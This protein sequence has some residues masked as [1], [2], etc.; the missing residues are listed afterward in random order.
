M[1]YTIIITTVGT[2]MFSNYFD[3]NSKSTHKLI[4]DNIKKMSFTETDWSNLSKD[5]S[6]QSFEKEVGETWS[7]FSCAELDT[8]TE[9]KKTYGENV[10]HHLLCSET[11]AGVLA[12]KILDK[13]LGEVK[14]NII[15][16]KLQTHIAKGFKETVFLK[17]VETVQGIAENVNLEKQAIAILLSLEKDEIKQFIKKVLKEKTNIEP[18]KTLFTK[19]TNNQPWKEHIISEQVANEIIVISNKKVVINYSGGYKAVI[20][21][22]TILGQLYDYDLAYMHEDS[23]KEGEG[24]ITTKRLPFNFDV[25]LAEM[26]YPYLTKF[27][28]SSEN[29]KTENQKTENQKTENQSL[30]ISFSKEDI[31][32]KY[33]TLVTEMLDNQLL[34]ND[35][36]EYKITAFGSILW[37]YVDTKNALGKNP[38]SFYVELK[39]YKFYITQYKEV[40]NP[41]YS[42]VIHNEEFTEKWIDEKGKNKSDNHEIDLKLIKPDENFIVVEVKSFGEVFKNEDLL[43][44]ATKRISAYQKKEFG[45]KKPE[46]YHLVFYKTSNDKE[47]FVKDT[48]LNLTT[49]IAKLDVAFKAFYIDISLEKS[50][51][52]YFSFMQKELEKI[53]PFQI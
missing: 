21:Y 50:R 34:F 19:S 12:G 30:S 31:A 22:L 40:E 46:E 37:N 9:I 47:E 52:P 20:P 3:K 43:D 1:N 7:V 48:I 29:Q 6:F 16:E 10:E 32:N 36:G 25:S 41:T 15:I 38:L 4:W 26:Y 18:F 17:L 27:K 33:A 51:N 35:N 45:G 23:N 11:I 49:E 53:E 28:L 42:K 24:L 2:S 8:I 39:L 5:I 13:K 44:R 14:S